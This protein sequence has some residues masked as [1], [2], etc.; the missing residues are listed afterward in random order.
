M[1]NLVISK[2]KFFIAIGVLFVLSVIILFAGISVSENPKFCNTCHIMKPYYKAWKDSAH[3]N[4]H[5]LDCHYEP[6][7]RSHLKGKIN[8]LVQV[9]DYVT[10][11]YSERAVA[12]IGDASCLRDGCHT[13]EKII[14]TKIMFK[15]KV[16]FNHATHW[17]DFDEMGKGVHLRC[18]TC[19]SWLT[20][21]KHISVDENTCFI[22][23]F[24]NVPVEKITEQCQSC[25]TEVERIAGHK[26]Y[27]AEG[28]HCAEC[29]ATIKTTN[30]P[31]L[32]QMCYFCHA[33]SEK[34]HKADEANKVKN[35]EFLHQRHI[36]Q[37]N[38]DCINCHELIKHGKEN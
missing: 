29:H 38:A 15:D 28:M 26:E 6:N 34:I 17:R 14:N 31:V 24:K 1:S 33:D 13:K 37:N 16:S 23:H 20:Y 4:V 30:A 22:C 36:T 12:K 27:L 21:D 7:W 8:G 18:T 2:K 35:R 3:K 11:R 9:I 25:H 19:H 32:Q 5:C 10:G